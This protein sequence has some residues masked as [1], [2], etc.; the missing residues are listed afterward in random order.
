MNA[1][2]TITPAGTAPLRVLLNERNALSD[3]LN[4]G[5]WTDEA[6]AVVCADIDRLEATIINQPAATADDAIVKLVTLAQIAASDREIEDREAISV[7]ADAQRHLGLGRLDPAHAAFVDPALPVPAADDAI[8]SAYAARRREYEQNY[9]LEMT[10]EESDAYFN[11]IDAYESVIH[12]PP[13][14]TIAG[15]LAKLRVTFVHQTGELWSDRAVADVNHPA[16]VEGLA[17]AGTFTRQAWSAIEDLARIG[18]VDL[19][20]QGRAVAA[21]VPFE[22]LRLEYRALD[23]QLK[24]TIT[25]ADSDPRFL[26]IQARMK[27]IEQEVV[28]RPARSVDDARAKMR[29][30]LDTASIGIPLDGEEAHILIKDAAR[31]LLGEE[32]GA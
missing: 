31:F 23:D 12:G 29:F 27:Q 18:G 26:T 25:D 5:A 21:L 8:L 1:P 22:A 9:H 16:F 32:A 13:A 30:M 28:I 4:E 19:A 24:S 11:R 6:G 10:T 14:T 20:A 2:I 3:R 15:V 17:T 7:V